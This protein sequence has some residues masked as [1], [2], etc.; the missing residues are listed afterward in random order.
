MNFDDFDKKNDLTAVCLHFISG[1]MGAAMLDHGKSRQ[2]RS[3][4]NLKKGL[5]PRNYTLFTPK[6]N[7][8]LF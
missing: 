8:N 2:S 6:T 4:V 5:A 1:F 3:S 7:D